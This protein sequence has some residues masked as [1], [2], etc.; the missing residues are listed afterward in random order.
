MI[1]KVFFQ[2][3]GKK[4]KASV[5]ADSPEEAKQ[6]IKNEIIFDKVVLMKHHFQTDPTVEHLKDILGFNKPL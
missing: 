1:Y 5:Q 3:Y 4:M 2:L 6:E